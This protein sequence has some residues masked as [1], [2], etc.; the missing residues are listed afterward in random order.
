MKMFVAFAVLV[1]SIIALSKF[2]TSSPVYTLT[3]QEGA[4]PGTSLSQPQSTQ[5]DCNA[6]GCNRPQPELPAAARAGACSSGKKDAATAVS[7]CCKDA[8]QCCDACK[9]GGT[10]KCAGC[11]CCCKK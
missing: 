8:C 6:S 11:K 9:K 10:C 3:G 2:A 4:A 5:P 7:C 1:A